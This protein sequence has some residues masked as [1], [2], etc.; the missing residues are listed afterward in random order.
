MDIVNASIIMQG[1]DY[2]FLLSPKFSH[3]AKGFLS[4]LMILSFIHNHHSELHSLTQ[5]I[6]NCK[7]ASI[8]SI[9]HKILFHEINPAPSSTI[10][11]FSRVSPTIVS[12]LFH[13]C[14]HLEHNRNSFINNESF[15][16]FSEENIFLVGWTSS[17]T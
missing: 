12:S 1:N 10:H 17:D 6:M 15:K 11:N 4:L 13:S 7:W 14:D 2:A 9:F 3:A 16:K 5:L 8:C